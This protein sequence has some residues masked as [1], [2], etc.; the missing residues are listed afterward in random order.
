MSMTIAQQIRPPTI[1]IYEWYTEYWPLPPA[2]AAGNSFA[3]GIEVYAVATAN[4][5]MQHAVPMQI[6]NKN[7]F[8]T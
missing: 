5:M 4:K 8:M 3:S 6:Q 2:Q 1:D 7:I